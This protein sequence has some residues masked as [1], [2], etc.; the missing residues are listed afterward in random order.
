MPF[1]EKH[2]EQIIAKPQDDAFPSANPI[3]F[4]HVM[5]MLSESV[6]VLSRGG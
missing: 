4:R 2:A 5:A 1:M 6:A 3:P